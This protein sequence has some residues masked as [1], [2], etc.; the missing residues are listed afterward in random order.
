MPPAPEIRA[1][2]G[3]VRRRQSL[4]E[5]QVEEENRRAAPIVAP[6]VEA[7]IEATIDH[8]KR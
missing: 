5:M 3:L 4:I 6:A 1:L 2:Q 8:V 7:S